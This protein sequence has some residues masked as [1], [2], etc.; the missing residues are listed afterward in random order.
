M[1]LDFINTGPTE[2]DLARGL[3]ERLAAKT[4]ALL[5]MKEGSIDVTIVDDELIR[6]V[7]RTYR[8]LDQ[9]TDVLSFAFLE[10]EKEPTLPDQPIALG[11]IIISFE[12]A[13]KEA[14]E[15]HK[16]LLAE[17]GLLFV[18]GLL[19]L[20]GYDHQTPDD[21]KKMFTLQDL[22]LKGETPC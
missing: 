13:Q 17:L 6:K 7:N 22:I 11:E 21:L 4:F 15:D 14:R 10:G 20:L 12:T 19:H 5:K 8:Q 1:A 16:P 9:A 18:H 2:L 3:F